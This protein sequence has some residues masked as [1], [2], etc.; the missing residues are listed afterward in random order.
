MNI[1]EQIFSSSRQSK[2]ITNDYEVNKKNS[3]LP[4]IMSAVDDN[5]VSERCSVIFITDDQEWSLS[6]IQVMN[7][8]LKLNLC[9]ENYFCM[10]LTLISLNVRN[11]AN[12]LCEI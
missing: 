12:V 2:G 7:N 3:I 4:D 11:L 1:A 9:W 8:N 10:K 5:L 6:I